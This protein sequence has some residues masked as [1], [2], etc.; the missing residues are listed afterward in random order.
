MDLA[1]YEL[2]RLAL[3]YEH[4]GVFLR[5]GI[6]LMEGLG[7]VDKLMRGAN[8]TEVKAL[9]CQ[10]PGTEVIMYHEDWAEGRRYKDDF[11]AAKP[12]A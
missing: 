8:E 3:L 7:W 11:I 9:S 2:L 4:G 5:P 1:V 10:L 6:I 12:K